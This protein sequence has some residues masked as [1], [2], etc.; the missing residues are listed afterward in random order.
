MLHAALAAG[1]ILVT[2]VVAKL[3]VKRLRRARS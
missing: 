1:V 2:I 3:A